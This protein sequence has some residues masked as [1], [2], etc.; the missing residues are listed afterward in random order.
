MTRPLEVSEK[1]GL[2]WQAFDPIRRELTHQ[3][4]RDILTA[5]TEVESITELATY[6]RLAHEVMA[7][8]RNAAAVAAMLVSTGIKPTPIDYEDDPV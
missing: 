6:M 2:W 5:A 3:K 8:D 1:V 4:F 7:N